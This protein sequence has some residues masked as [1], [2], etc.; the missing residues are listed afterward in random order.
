M[1]LIH[2][3]ELS[4]GDPFHFLVTL[5]KQANS[6][7]AN[8]G[9]WLPWNYR[10]TLARETQRAAPNAGAPM[11]RELNVT[12]VPAPSTSTPEPRPP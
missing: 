9:D 7:A 12:W 8:P 5:L 11:P 2:T 3:T 6:V 10:E 1:S 4:G